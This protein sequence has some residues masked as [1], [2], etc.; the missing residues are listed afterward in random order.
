MTESINKIVRKTC[1]VFGISED[2][3]K[4]KKRSQ[5]LVYARMICAKCIDSC[6][7]VYSTTIAKVL[8]RDSSTIRYYLSFF[9]QEYFHNKDFRNFADA[10]NLVSLDIKS[11]FHRELEQE[12]NEIIG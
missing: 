5:E 7:G 12:L 8:D 9:E 4:S 2:D 6:C 3:L 11:D 10:V 1:S